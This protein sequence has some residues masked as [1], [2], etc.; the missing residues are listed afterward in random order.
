MTTVLDDTRA[1]SV[2]AE[3]SRAV[4]LG[5]LTLVELRKLADTRAGLWLLIV[6]GLATVGT[7]AIMLGF[8][9]DAEQTFEGFYGFGLLPSAAY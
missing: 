6:I 1:P 4:P 2:R 9:T 7:S 8:S 3:S 5:R